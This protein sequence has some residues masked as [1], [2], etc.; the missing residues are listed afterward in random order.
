MGGVC[1]PVGIMMCEYKPFPG[2][3]GGSQA[4]PD[5]PGRGGPWPQHSVQPHCVQG[6]WLRGCAW[7]PRGWRGQ[8][9]VLEF[10]RPTLSLRSC[11]H[12]FLLWV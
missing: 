9:A 11:S 6:R 7:P 4:R 10:F 3:D 8:R 12:T 2:K 5:C 1:G